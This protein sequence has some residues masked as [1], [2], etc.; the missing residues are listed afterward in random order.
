MAEGVA[1]PTD[2]RDFG[3]GASVLADVGPVLWQAAMRKGKGITVRSQDT[4]QTR[5]CH[6]DTWK[7][8][9]RFSTGGVLGERGRR[10]LRSPGH[11]RG[12]RTS[13]TPSCWRGMPLTK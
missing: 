13:W 12:R 9:V 7:S 5:I 6:I 3:A 10:A 8:S 2:F 1:C 4:F 11:G